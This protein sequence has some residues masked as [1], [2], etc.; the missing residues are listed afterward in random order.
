MR[1]PM[2]KTWERIHPRFNPKRQRG[3]VAI[4]VA[5]M[6]V[7]IVGA[8]VVYSLDM[9]SSEVTDASLSNRDLEARMLAEAGLERAFYLFKNG[10]VCTA[11]GVDGPHSFGTGTFTIKSGATEGLNCRV[12]VV[13]QAG[14]ATTTLTGVTTPGGPTSYSFHE[15]FENSTLF[16]ATWSLPV[17]SKS[18][19]SSVYDDSANCNVAACSGAT[20][21][22]MVMQSDLAGQNDQYIG[23]RQRPISAIDTSIFSSINYSVAFKKFYQSTKV[24]AQNI[25]VVLVDSSSGRTQTI[26]SENNSMNDNVWHVQAGA[27]SLTG[28]R[29]Y[30]TLRVEFTIR[31]FKF[32]QVQI[33]VDEISLV[34]P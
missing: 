7:L 22:S 14:A 27:V 8:A 11:L 2:S 3:A 31:E 24:N 4:T 18:N 20:G 29:I 25:E 21:G 34:S 15:P 6:F 10:T 26:W 32:N 19:G 1:G 9:G 16:D 28:G 17:L 23:Y 30:D 12:T 33:W 5:I 13:A